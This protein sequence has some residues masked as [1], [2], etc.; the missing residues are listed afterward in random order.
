MKRRW[1]FAALAGGL[2]LTGIIGLVAARQSV[3]AYNPHNLI[4][5]HIV[6]NSNT[7]ADQVLK[8]RVRD[9]VVQYLTPEVQDVHDAFEARRIV[10]R[11]LGR[12]R[13]VAEREVRA[14]G[15]NYPVQVSFGCYHF[16]ARTYGTLTVLEGDYQAVR[17]VIGEGKGHNWWCVLFPPLC[18]VSV[19]A[20]A[21]TSVLASRS[22]DVPVRGAGREVQLRWRVRELWEKSA[23]LADNIAERFNGKEKRS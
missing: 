3:E 6:P 16:P 23:R 14:A 7:E 13:A 17:V 19:D 9:A 22:N 5:F 2:I 10:L 4:R 12:I 15:K 18:F 1:V 20:G 21:D 8:L 11:E